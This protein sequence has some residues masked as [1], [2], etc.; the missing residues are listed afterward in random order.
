MV[1]IPQKKQDFFLVTDTTGL[2]AVF[3]RP[4]EGK[5]VSPGMI[6]AHAPTAAQQCRHRKAQRDKLTKG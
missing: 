3:A 4:N 1:P 5:E 2:D 6:E